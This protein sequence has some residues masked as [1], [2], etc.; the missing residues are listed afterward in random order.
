M[1]GGRKGTFFLSII[2]QN[3]SVPNLLKVFPKYLFFSDHAIREIS[4]NFNYKVN[5]KDF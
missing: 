5:F 3:R 4:L 2:D 1:S